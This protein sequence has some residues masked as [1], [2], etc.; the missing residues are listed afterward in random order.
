MLKHV[1]YRVTTGLK[2]LALT[3]LTFLWDLFG[4]NPGWDIGY[5]DLI[6]SWLSSVPPGDCWGN[7]S[8]KPLPLPSKSFPIQH[9]DASIIL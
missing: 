3:H 8:T 1:V 7:T 9:Y 5:P 6:F 4:S 2:G